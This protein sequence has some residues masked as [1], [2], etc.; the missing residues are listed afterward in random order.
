M[1]TDRAENPMRL[2]AAAL[3][4]AVLALSA[5]AAPTGTTVASSGP[6]DP[7]AD[8]Q[9]IQQVAAKVNGRSSDMRISERRATPDGQVLSVEIKGSCSGWICKLDSAG[10]FRS[11]EQTAS[12]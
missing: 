6:S 10:R 11:I 1:F 12:D 9:C 4:A 5:C 3:S 2:A 8:R 7:G